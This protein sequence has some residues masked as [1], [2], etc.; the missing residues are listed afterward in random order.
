VC[1]YLTE[2]C[3]LGKEREE[4]RRIMK[5]EQF[6]RQKYMQLNKEIDEAKS[7]VRLHKEDLKENI[8]ARPHVVTRTVGLQAVLCPRTVN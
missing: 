2:R 6:W 7:V 8:N 3:A 5:R 1:E 4:I